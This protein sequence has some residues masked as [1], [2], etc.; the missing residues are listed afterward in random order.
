MLWLFPDIF[1]KPPSDNYLLNG[2]LTLLLLIGF[3]FVFGVCSKSEP[4][5][6]NL[7]LEFGILNLAKNLN[8]NL[9]KMR[10]ITIKL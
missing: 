4:I 8:V 6:E 3:L 5:F 9:G 7:Y 10:T 2:L 1:S